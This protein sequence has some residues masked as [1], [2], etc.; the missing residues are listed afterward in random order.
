MT[1][2]ILGRPTLAI[3][4]ALGLSGAC[5]ADEVTDQIEAA[6]KA[7][8]AKE[9]H[10]SVQ[11]LDFAVAKI[12]ERITANLL[13]LLPAPRD[14]WEADPAESQSGGVAAMLIGTTLSRRYRGPD[15]AGVELKLMADSP[16]MPM[17]TMAL[18]MPFM[19]QANQNQKPY[20]LGGNRGT[21]E[22]AADGRDYEITLLVG[23]RLVVQAKGTNLADPK[24]V[25]LY[26]EA[27]DLDAI[28]K[29][30]TD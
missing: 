26:L 29:A 17:L 10:A 7:Y 22:H 25:E 16:L 28:Q 30:L 14:G 19:V 15:G 5:A 13:T 27:L 1:Q 6:R 4:I 11:A 21:M 24:P 3:T 18:S 8:E 23:N 12:R 9:L 20:S 2:M